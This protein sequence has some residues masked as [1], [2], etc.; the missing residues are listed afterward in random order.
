MCTTQ[1]ESV[2]NCCYVCQKPRPV[3]PGPRG[4]LPREYMYVRVNPLSSSSSHHASSR[5]PR[6]VTFTAGLCEIRTAGLSENFV[7]R[8]T[9]SSRMRKVT[10]VFVQSQSFYPC[11]S[12]SAPNSKS[13]F[14]SRILLLS[15]FQGKSTSKLGFAVTGMEFQL[16]PRMFR[17][18][19]VAENGNSQ[20][21]KLLQLMFAVRGHKVHARC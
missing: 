9:P 19:R 16:Q 6:D 21:D 17:L 7:S 4:F 15:Q 12:Y 8:A 3:L 13:R 1:C 10:R 20:L 2:L 14:R 18:W 5:E 11:N